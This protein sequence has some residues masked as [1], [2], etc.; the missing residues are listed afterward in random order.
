METKKHRAADLA[1]TDG[2]FIL[3]HA[4]VTPAKHT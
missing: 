4:L 1:N 3:Y 2:D